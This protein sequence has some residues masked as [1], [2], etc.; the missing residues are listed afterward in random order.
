[1]FSHEEVGSYVARLPREDNSYPTPISLT[2]R[3]ENGNIHRIFKGSSEIQ[4][5]TLLSQAFQFQ[6]KQ[7]GI[8]N[9]YARSE[10]SVSSS[11]SECCT[12][13]SL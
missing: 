13:S 12:W 3:N 1:M 2:S 7:E 11:A 5:D 8:R 6:Q 9:G 4:T 10:Q